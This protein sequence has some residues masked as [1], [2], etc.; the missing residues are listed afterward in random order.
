MSPEPNAWLAL[1]LCYGSRLDAYAAM[2]SEQLLPYLPS[3]EKEAQ[4][5]SVLD[6]RR[7]ARWQREL[8]K[9]LSPSMSLDKGATYPRAMLYACV[10]ADPAWNAAWLHVG[11]AMFAAQFRIVARRARAWGQR[12]VYHALMEIAKE[13][14]VHVSRERDN[15]RALNCWEPQLLRRAA[16]MID[17][18]NHADLMVLEG[19]PHAL[20]IPSPEFLASRLVEDLVK[21]G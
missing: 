1:Y 21:E 14:T 3:P 12:E 13:E 2:A 16:S 7:H 10:T 17:A 19:L 9:D 18:V 11:E 5:L 8:A 6:E 15:L 4:A 20:G